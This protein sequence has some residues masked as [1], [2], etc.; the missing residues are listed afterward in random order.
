[1]KKICFAGIFFLLLS[2][3]A[4]SGQETLPTTVKVNIVNTKGKPMKDI[5]AL[6]YVG[7]GA[8]VVGSDNFG[9][10][11][12]EAMPDDTVKVIFGEKI[13]AVPI[14]GSKDIY[15]F[16]KNKNKPNAFGRDRLLA[17]EHFGQPMSLR[18]NSMALAAVEMV[19]AQN[20]LTLTDYLLGRVSGV[21]V[22]QGQVVIRGGNNSFSG[23]STP[24]AVV[25]GVI[26]D[27]ES[28]NAMVVPADIKSITVNKTGVGYGSRGANGV[29]IITTKKGNEND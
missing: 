20:Y 29:I 14:Q 28:A 3:I 2:Q 13:Y 5:K 21:Y 4:L 8:H 19:G 25:D 7:D 16:M 22:N 18:N 15:V 9:V 24:L 23:S 1:M 10:F 6:G 17:V 27:Y 11:E 26:M 12:I